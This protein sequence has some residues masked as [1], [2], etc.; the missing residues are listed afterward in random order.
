MSI[1]SIVL[2]LLKRKTNMPSKESL[3]NNILTDPKIKE[4]LQKHTPGNQHSSITINISD[5]IR[6][7]A[8]RIALLE[9]EIYLLKNDQSKLE[10]PISTDPE[11]KPNVEKLEVIY[12]ST[13]NLDGSFNL[14]SSSPNYRDGATIYKFTKT[15]FNK[16]RFEIDSKTD[17]MK[18]AISYPDKN[19]DPVCDAEN[20]FNSNATRIIT[21]QPGEVELQGDKWI[22]I[23]K[24]KI[25]YEG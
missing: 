4:H 11:T 17:S 2:S 7:L 1:I 24:A 21:V 15:S 22:K 10:K 23:T 8:E 14:S 3:I 6:D 9:K 5:Q 12:L 25:R 20:A 13:P 19:I 16:A 18:L